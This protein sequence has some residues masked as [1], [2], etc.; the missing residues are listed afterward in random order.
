MKPWESVAVTLPS[1][2]VSPP[3]PEAGLSEAA[4]LGHSGRVSL[5]SSHRGG[6]CL[7]GPDARAGVLPFRRGLGPESPRAREPG[8]AGLSGGVWA[9]A[10]NPAGGVGAEVPAVVACGRRTLAVSA[11]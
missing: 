6:T 2:T 5:L 4:A 3:R 1:G 11:A 9:A 8:E 7:R 10:P